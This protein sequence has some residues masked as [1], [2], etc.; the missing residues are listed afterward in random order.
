MAPTNPRQ[1]AQRNNK[2]TLRSL[3]HSA[4][5]T[6]SSSSSNARHH[7][8]HAASQLT[9]QQRINQ[10]KPIIK[11]RQFKFKS[12]AQQMRSIQVDLQRVQDR[13]TQL[14]GEDDD[15]LDFQGQGRDNDEDEDEDDDDE[16]NSRTLFG[17]ALRQSQL[18][19]LS[20]PF[21]M[22]CRKLEPKTRSLPLV[23]HYKHDIVYELCSSLSQQPLKD[24]E[25]CGQTVLDLLPPLITDLDKLLL[26]YLTTIV[27][28]L[29]SLTQPS[30]LLQTS[31]QLLQ[32]V[33]EV[34]GV[35]FRDLARY[36]L[37]DT[38]IDD[39][40]NEKL[41]DA[42]WNIV[43]RGLGAPATTS[44]SETVE[45]E[46]QEDGTNPKETSNNDEDDDEGDDEEVEEADDNMHLAPVASTSTQLGSQITLSKI[47]LPTTLPHHFRT[48]PQTRRLL[49]SS[50]A[51]LV[52]KASSANNKHLN[53]TGQLELLI[54]YL[55]QDL[56]QVEQ[57]DGATRQIKRRGSASTTSS[58]GK[59]RGQEDGSSVL[60]A[61]GLAWLIAEACCGANNV[62]HSKTSAIVRS[63]MSSC[64]KH[65]NMGCSL[66]RDIMTHS[67]IVIA[68]HVESAERLDAVMDELLN[69]IKSVK[70]QKDCIVVIEALQTLA[71]TKKSTCISVTARNRLFGTIGSLNT[72]V[73]TQ[74]NLESDFVTTY[75]TLI[76]TMSQLATFQQILSGGF[77]H[78]FETLFEQTLQ[79]SIELFDAGSALVTQL[80]ESN[81][82]YF[83]TLL[84]SILFDN[85]I[86]MLQTRDE[87]ITNSLL[88]RKWIGLFARLARSTRLGQMLLTPSVQT[89]LVE[90]VLIQCCSEAIES[91]LE[92]SER[93]QEENADAEFLDWLSIIAF[94]E[95]IRTNLQ[96]S[97]INL[98]IKFA[99]ITQTKAVEEFESSPAN[100]SQILAVLLQTVS[101]V[102]AQRLIPHAR[103]ILDGF[104]WHRGV[105]SSVANLGIFTTA[106]TTTTSTI[107]DN[108]LFSNVLRNLL[109]E[110]SSLRLSSLRIVLAFF[111]IDKGYSIEVDLINKCIEVEQMALTV[112]GAR[113][114][115]MKIRKIGIV[116]HAQLDNVQEPN[117]IVNVIV[118][119]LTAMLKL[120]FKPVW[121]EAIQALSLLAEKYPEVVWRI[122]SKQLLSASTRNYDELFVVST[123]PV[124]TRKEFGMNM[125][126]TTM[127]GLEPL[128]QEKELRD[129][130]VEDPRAKIV[131]NKQICSAIHKDMIQDVGLQHLRTPQVTSDRLDIQSFEAQLLALY[132]AL[133]NLAQKHNRDFVEVFLGCFQR[134][135]D[136]QDVD[137]EIKLQRYVHVEETTKERKQRLLAWLQLFAKLNN[138]KALFRS[139]ELDRLFR[140][141]LAFPDVAVQKLALD[142]VL[143]WKNSAIQANADRL[144]NLLEPTKL[145]DELLQFVSTTDAGGLDPEHRDDV[146]PLFIRI[147]YGI[148]TSRLGRASSSSGQGRAGRR[149]A[150]LGA[151][152]TCSS[153]ELDTLVDLT[154]GPLQ[155]L[156]VARTDD[157]DD[158]FKFASH[159]PNVP[160]RR[161]VGFL[162]LL[163]DVVKHLGPQIVKRWHDLMGATLN[164][165]YFAQKGIENE[166]ANKIE[167]VA[168]NDEVQQQPELDDEQEQQDGADEV[169]EEQTALAP[170]RHIRQLALK[171]LTD[172]FKQDTVMFDY[173]PYVK[174]AFPV[175]ISPRLPTLPMENAQAPSA[176]LELFASWAVRRDLVK[177]LVKFDD[178]LL[179]SLYGVL[180]VRNVKSTVVLRVFDIVMSLL[181]FAND[182][183]GVNSEVAQTIV[184]PGVR[185][186]LSQLSGSLQSTSTSAD[187]RAELAQRQ[188]MV[189][190]ALAPYVE[191]QQQALDFLSLI[192]PLLRK[193]NKVV[194]EKVKTDLLKIFTT[195]YPLARPD[196]GS[197]LRLRCFE[198]VSSLFLTARTRQARLQAV[199][200]F[201]SFA[202][203]EDT[204]ERVSHLV[205]ELNSYSVKRSEEPDF[206]R[207]LAAFTSLNERLYNQLKAVEWIPL[208]NCMLFFVQDPEELAIRSN[209]SFS[210]QRFIEVVAASTTADEELRTILTRTLLPGLK[211]S[212]RAKIEIVRADVLGVFAVA[213][214]KVQGVAELD[215]MKCLLVGGDQEANFFYNVL[216]IQVHR[217]SRALRRLADEVERGSIK[218]KVVADVFLPLIDQFIVGAA[219]G[220]KDADLVNE[221]VQCLARLAKHL[222]WSAW[223]KQASHY[224]KFA[225]LTGPAQKPC[226]R[227]LVAVLKGFH[228]DLESDER[229]RGIVMA[230]L[231]PD[232]LTYIEKRDAADEEVRIPIGEGAAAIVQNLP[233]TDRNVQQSALMMALS[234]ILRS[235]DQTTRDAT[236]HTICNIVATAPDMLTVAIRELRRAL[237]RGPQLHV[238]AFTLHAMLVR[239]SEL[240]QVVRPV[241]FDGALDEIV[242][243]IGFDVFGTPQRERQSQEFK[244]KTKFKEVKSFKSIDSFQILSRFVSP[245]KIARLLQPIR[246]AMSATESAKT[247]KDVDEVLKAIVAGLT[248]NNKLDSATTLELCHSLIS[249]NSTFLKEAKVA[250]KNKKAAADY[251]VQLTRNGTNEEVNHYSKNAHRF[252]GFGLDLFNSSF[253]KSQ[254]DL[255]STEVLSRL[256]PL[257]KLVG[258]TLYSEEPVILARGM[259]AMASLIRCKLSNVENAA[260]VLIKQMLTIVQRSGSTESDLTQSTLRTL[261]IVIRD[262]K[263]ATLKDEQLTDL[264][265]LIA[266]DLEEADRQATLFQLLRA[267]MSRKFVAPEIYDLMDKV[268][269]ILVTNQ[270]SNVREI[271]R[272]IYLQFLL[273]YPQGRGRLK[274]SL[275]FL[276][277]NLSFIYESGR[278]SVLELLSA[279]FNKFAS[280]LLI[281]SAEL[282]FASLVMVVAND[283]S[284]KCRE[285]AAELV[286]VLLTRLEQDKKTILLTMLRTWARKNEQPQ[287]ARTAVQLFGIAVEALEGDQGRNAASDIVDILVD[288]LE[289]SSERLE[290]AELQ[291]EGDEPFELESVW[292]LPYQAL[293]ALGHVYKTFPELVST[294][295]GGVDD[296]DSTVHL[297]W[298]TVR[299]HLLYPHNWI[300]TSAAR[301]LGNLFASSSSQELIS[302][303]DLPMNDPLSTT[304]LLDTSQKSCLQLKSNVLTEQLSLQIVKNLFF[305]A[306]CFAARR[307][308]VVV[309]GQQQVDDDDD[310]DDEEEQDDGETQEETKERDPLR[311]L[312]TRLSYQAR[313]AHQHRPSMF[314]SE[315]GQWS[316]QP[317]SI[318]RW[319]AAVV[320]FLDESTIEQFLVH[321]ITPMFRII[322]D[323]NAQD[324][325]MVELQTLAQQV[326]EI[327]QTKVG[328]TK[329]VTIYTQIRQRASQRRH[330]RKIARAQEVLN[331]PVEDA[332][333]RTKRNEQKARQRKRKNAAFAD[334]KGRL[335]SSKKR[336]Q[337]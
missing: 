173:E 12:P 288:I 167:D 134:D 74:S 142:C 51:F 101:D 283:D 179:P 2:K 148:M 129:F 165:L 231:L 47:V 108:Q 250:R 226:V 102:A 39:E 1:D 280:S 188:I 163:A 28:T 145:R 85:G 285:M 153:S 135:E 336:R 234:A 178:R 235:K 243:V 199:A 118:R 54:D 109:S 266:P 116:A 18:N 255:D 3:R 117:S 125:T 42:V 289:K 155:K 276:A 64:F 5:T 258:N 323:P 59:G 282:F 170:L 216:H 128:F 298:S 246:D 205:E 249:Q 68:G 304:S 26:P 19:N 213:V 131:I 146:V 314:D 291:D 86:K 157:D 292:Q 45:K 272:S 277:K 308:S 218:S 227:S 225:K 337:E 274:Q 114:K 222:D 50:F 176:L 104:S 229:L 203:V 232:L 44:V 184:K 326:Q 257:V 264:L 186:L 335:G 247:L 123:K 290:Q 52:R 156:I 237:P 53:R 299:R 63:T 313:F 333:R 105:M 43:R 260:P 269:E 211:K 286:K 332:K 84:T 144:R 244:S 315:A 133:P 195:L 168:M 300:R 35:L 251:H 121:P 8:Q 204:V 241:D 20:L 166:A 164:L 262:I 22:L 97:L 295:N 161:Q 75:A 252:V 254:F 180:T 14:E 124:W 193:T 230:K 112:I 324:P 93:V 61:E 73:Q 316:R 38:T 317:A 320:S 279:I 307:A 34:L 65:A 265:N 303:V 253:R 25:L 40:N 58:K 16:R 94:I 29:V 37:S 194:P 126:T 152:K 95:P 91:V 127:R 321:M 83:Q 24:I 92:R 327:V 41:F 80:D 259:R 55:F 79:S 223:I 48:T 273:D 174:A 162:N 212:M 132:C 36:I 71:S 66:P 263:S 11:G 185:I 271:C 158:E 159:S 181:D 67:L 197:P 189:L 100:C 294:R 98:C 228:F 182:E 319:F 334:G 31:P 23:V 310:E 69:S 296:S 77:K 72:F 33:Y 99:K 136:E 219:E 49:A 196:T 328:S 81:W 330:D 62:L 207:R 119:Y 46:Q 30:P 141:Q 331:N 183:G 150:I 198:V 245:T 209:A 278:L 301:L 293:Q 242:P 147:T 10:Q 115:S 87:E 177:F 78:V 233:G 122:S 169:E 206:D 139:N 9:R 130:H 106:S 137:N 309:K 32:R 281:D 151:L 113:E 318:L 96:D 236:R 15:Q 6:S 322:E 201:K 268:A 217:R 107:E 275:T 4:A 190:C 13:R 270:S 171:R 57:E 82:N 149:A 192:T 214:D 191:D 220:G 202:A 215:Q 17:Q 175:I 208:I 261:A 200:A 224:L 70:S 238:L 110:D 172:F 311:W 76:S 140:R 154:L 27:T 221:T 248:M 267:I 306:K 239:L 287:L 240:D 305:T 89:K 187:A 138:P 210:L 90:N 56:S 111:P 297:L 88:K 302:K 120:N 7:K 329:F 284:T 256:E 143:R 103:D 325:Q 60:L 160:G 21:V 312:F